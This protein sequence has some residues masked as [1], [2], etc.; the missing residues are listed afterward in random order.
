MISLSNSLRFVSIT[1][2][3]QVYL[4]TPGNRKLREGCQFFLHGKAAS[5]SDPLGDFPALVGN[6][7]IVYEKFVNNKIIN[8]RKGDWHL[9]YWSFETFKSQQ[10]CQ[11]LLLGM[12]IFN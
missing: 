7:G 3:C 4:Y 11:V 6:G 2:R 10:S 8:H 12:Y 1:V 9:P 5:L